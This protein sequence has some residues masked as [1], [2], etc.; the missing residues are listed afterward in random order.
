[1]RTSCCSPLQLPLPS[2]AGQRYK[3]S[4]F[5]CG[6]DEEKDAGGAMDSNRVKLQVIAVVTFPACCNSR[7]CPAFFFI[8]AVSLFKRDSWGIDCFI[9]WMLFPHSGILSHSPLTLFRLNGIWAST[10]W[11]NFNAKQTLLSKGFTVCFLSV[12]YMH[13][14]SKAH[15]QQGTKFHPALLLFALNSIKLTRTIWHRGCFFRLKL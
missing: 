15:L 9:A 1:M 14:C 3:P 7:C 13:T 2:L 5:L 11:H 12:L 10:T 6:Y 8:N 4:V